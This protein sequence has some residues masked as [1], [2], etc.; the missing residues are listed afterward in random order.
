MQF[1]NVSSWLRQ[2][3]WMQPRSYWPDVSWIAAAAGLNGMAVAMPADKHSTLSPMATIFMH[4]YNQHIQP[5]RKQFWHG[6]LVHVVV[7][8]IVL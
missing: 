2:V 7:R 8:F 3:P 6:T 1:C 4:A 5:I